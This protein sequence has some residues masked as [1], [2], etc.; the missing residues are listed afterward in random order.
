MIIDSVVSLTLGFGNGPRGALTSLWFRLLQ[1]MRETG[2][3]RFFFIRKYFIYK[4]T[5]AENGSKKKKNILRICTGSAFYSRYET[6]YG[7]CTQFDQKFNFCITV[8]RLAVV[9]IIYIKILRLIICCQDVVI[10]R[11]YETDICQKVRNIEAETKKH[12]YIKKA[13]TV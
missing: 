13:C 12:S 8:S 1:C 10:L 7:P 3:T 11:I 5:E 4:N 6:L 2:P 9:N